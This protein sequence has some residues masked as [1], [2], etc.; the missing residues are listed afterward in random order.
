MSFFETPSIHGLI[1][2]PFMLVTNPD[3]FEGTFDGTFDE[4][5]DGTFDGTI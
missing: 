1:F 3:T 4:T 2:V 5:F